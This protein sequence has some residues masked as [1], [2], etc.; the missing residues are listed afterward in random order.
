M[1][2][3]DGDPTCCNQQNK[4]RM[5]TGLFGGNIETPV[6]DNLATEAHVVFKFPR[7]ANLFANTG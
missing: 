6:F 2:R 5:I 4:N 7:S 1:S 3:V